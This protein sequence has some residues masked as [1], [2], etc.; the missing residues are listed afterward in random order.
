MSQYLLLKSDGNTDSA[1]VGLVDDGQ[2]EGGVLGADTYT[3]TINT[4][5]RLSAVNWFDTSTLY[6]NRRHP[7]TQHE[8][9]RFFDAE[10]DDVSFGG[11]EDWN[12][13]LAWDDDEGTYPYPKPSYLPSDGFSFELVGEIYAP[14]GGTYQFG[15]DGD[16]AVDVYID[17]QFVASWYG[18]HGPDGSLSAHS[19]SIDLT[20]GWHTIVSRQE[21]GGGGEAWAVGWNKP[22]D[23]SFSVI[24]ESSYRPPDKSLLFGSAATT[25]TTTTEEIA[26]ISAASLG[27]IQTVQRTAIGNALTSVNADTTLATGNGITSLADALSTAIAADQQAAASVVA[28]TQSFGEAFA[29]AVAASGLA[30]DVAAVGS[31]AVTALGQIEP[32]QLD[33]L[34]GELVTDVF[35]VAGPQSSTAGPQAASLSGETQASGLVEEAAVVPLTPTMSIVVRVQSSDLRVEG[36]FSD[37]LAASVGAQTFIKVAKTVGSAD[38]FEGAGTTSTTSPSNTSTALFAN[39]SGTAD[40]FTTLNA[41]ADEFAGTDLAAALDTSADTVGTVADLAGAAQSADDTLAEAVG[42][43]VTTAVSEVFAGVVNASAV[44]NVAV[45]LASLLVQQG[46]VD[47]R[48]TAAATVANAL[49]SDRRTTDIAVA[50]ANGL[51]T[52]LD[53]TDYTGRTRT[54]IEFSRLGTNSAL[55]EAEQRISITDSTNNI[56]IFD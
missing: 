46:A 34:G 37:S 1:S 12:Q 43:T 18:G 31:T 53:V 3:A 45:T 24:P 2:Y 35:V 26:A 55:V 54:F 42:G 16:D 11:A 8:M 49:T 10:R 19:G 5:Y 29:D 6:N 17:G 13:A 21:E 33:A 7:Q 25:T 51:A 22:S 47:S 14:E 30:Q 48:A 9:D 4:E 56:K 23:S 27:T 41:L 32:T 50:N 39:Q 15:V 28:G 52:P 36:K 40:T 38:T 20:T 44:A